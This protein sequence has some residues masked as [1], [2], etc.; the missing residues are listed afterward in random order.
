MSKVVHDIF[1]F[2]IDFLGIDWQ[3]KHVTFGFFEVEN[4]FGMTLA[5]NLIE[6]LKII[7]LT[8]SVVTYS[9]IRV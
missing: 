2:E 5:K 6:L 3:E 9:V 4:T 7:V 8:C 1:T